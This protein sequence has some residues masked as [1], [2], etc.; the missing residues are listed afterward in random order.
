MGKHQELSKYGTTFT[1]VPHN[2]KPGRFILDNGD[3]I[4]ESEDEIVE[5]V[6]DELDFD[7]QSLIDDKDATEIESS[8]FKF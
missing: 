8:M 7:I 5:E 1:L 4:E 3:N 2:E 6:G